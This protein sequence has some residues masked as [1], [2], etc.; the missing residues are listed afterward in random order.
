LAASRPS[1]KSFLETAHV[2]A[3]ASGKAIL[4]HFRKAVTIENKAPSGKPFDPVT[5]A[6]KAAERAIRKGLAARHPDHGI[7]GEEYGRE[8]SASP[9]TWVIDPIDGTKAFITGT[10][11]WGTLI[12]LQR[13]DRA[14]LG[15]MDQPFTGE[16]IW[17][18]GNGTTWRLPGGKAKRIKTRTCPR[19]EDA[20]IGTTNPDLLAPGFERDTFD[21]MKSKARMARFGGDCY[22]Y[23]LLAA[24]H[25]DIIA[26]CGLK[27]Y[28]IVALIPIIE[29]AGGRVTA[30]D[31]GPAEAGGRILA[32]G[33]P[34][35]H[36]KLLAFIAKR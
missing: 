17:S 33:D 29:A 14:I 18:D 2:L 11:L 9:Y 26:E 30:W 13:D 7:F 1:L 4:P 3:D 12:G 36:E 23:C 34:H 16:R 10:P 5:T 28:D 19:L 24:G 8:H 35:L 25:I 6:D 32:A 20:I 27:P 15:L 21:A 31:G 22:A